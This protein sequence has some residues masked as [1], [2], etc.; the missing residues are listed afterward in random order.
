MNKGSAQIISQGNPVQQGG[1]ATLNS[2]TL[3]TPLPPT[4]GGVGAM[5][6]APS[7]ARD[8]GRGE[9]SAGP[10]SGSITDYKDSPVGPVR[11]QSLPPT[12]WHYSLDR[13]ARLH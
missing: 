13:K 11:G 4:S 7:W 3:A 6:G 1:N 9:D 2:L 12:A 8:F 5:T 10:A